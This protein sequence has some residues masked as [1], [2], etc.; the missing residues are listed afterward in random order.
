[1]P[2]T[3]DHQKDVAF[4]IMAFWAGMKDPNEARKAAKDLATEAAKEIA[5]K[6]KKA[7]SKVVE[8]VK[9]RINEL[10]LKFK[11][12][13]LGSIKEFI[14]TL[15][16]KF[17]ELLPKLPNFSDWFDFPEF[18]F[19]LAELIPDLTGFFGIIG[20]AGSALSKVRSVGEGI[21]S[22]YS[23]ANLA[24]KLTKLDANGPHMITVNAARNAAALSAV[25]PIVKG[26]LWIGEKIAQANLPGIA[27]VAIALGKFLAAICGIAL[28][29]IQEHIFKKFRDFCKDGAEVARSANGTVNLTAF[30]YVYRVAATIV[31]DLSYVSLASGF[32]G[33]KQMFFAAVGEVGGDDSTFA[34]QIVTMDKAKAQIFKNLSASKHKDF[35]THEKDWVN[36]MIEGQIKTQQINANYE[37]MLKAKNFE[38]LLKRF[39][40]NK[41]HVQALADVYYALNTDASRGGGVL[42]AAGIAIDAALDMQ[43][44]TFHYAHSGAVPPLERA[45]SGS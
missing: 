4:S 37:K 21:K 3:V 24:Y 20:D 44:V 18:D 23:D 9:K 11:S 1:M 31:P 39:R 22:V 25:E 40:A 28:K 33:N 26:G 45:P 41:D 19:N 14:E 38:R 7:I 5:E 17:R 43:P 8:S 42:T 27:D 12:W 13:L 10:M 16:N 34:Q 2:F 6:G 15:K 36:Q 35:W 32:C 29:F 30:Q